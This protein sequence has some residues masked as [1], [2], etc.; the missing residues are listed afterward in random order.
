MLRA[1][2]NMQVKK[3]SEHSKTTRNAVFYAFVNQ[4]RDEKVSQVNNHK[5]R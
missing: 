4:E 2:L 3:R 5:K 1:L